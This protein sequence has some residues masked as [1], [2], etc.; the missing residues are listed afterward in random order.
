LKERGLENPRL[1]VGDGALGLWAAIRE[2]YPRAGQQRCWVHK[3]RNGLVCFRKRLQSQAKLLLREIY[4]A[5]TKEKAVALMDQFAA[6][7]SQNY[8]RAVECLLKDKPSKD[9]A[10]S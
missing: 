3:M 2:V 4:T 9:L 1:F 7:Y 6:R 5:A 10:C 8:P